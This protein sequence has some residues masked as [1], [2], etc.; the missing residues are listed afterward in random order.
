MVVQTCERNRIR[1]RVRI[2][3]HSPAVGRLCVTGVVTRVATRVVTRVVTAS[4]LK[5]LPAH[6][7]DGR[8]LAS[9]ITM[10]TS[11][12]AGKGAGAVS[13]RTPPA[14]GTGTAA[15]TE[16][17]AGTAAGT[18]VGAVPGTGTTLVVTGTKGSAAQIPLAPGK[19]DGTVG[20]VAGAP[21]TS[22][23]GGAVHP[24]FSDPDIGGA[25]HLPF[26]D[27]AAGG[28]V[29]AR[30]ALDHEVN[31]TCSC[32][33]T[34]THT[35]SVHTQPRSECPCERPQALSV[36]RGVSRCMRTGT[37][38]TCD[39]LHAAPTRP[40]P[41][42]HQGCE[43]SFMFPCSFFCF[44][45]A[46]GSPSTTRWRHG[47][48]ARLSFAPL[49]VAA[50]NCNAVSMSVSRLSRAAADARGGGHVLLRARV[51]GGFQTTSMGVNFL[52]PPAHRRARPTGVQ[53]TCR[54]A[55]GIE[56]P[57]DS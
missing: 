24:P 14:A 4:G 5:L 7:V 36:S 15:G 38:P 41:L 34:Q 33:A 51:R 49:T 47:L 20:A 53:R 48:V 28:A 50:C 32:S 54:Q 40:P 56:S 23:P 16:T 29:H 52:I 35:R 2:D 57:A 19:F 17:A 9:A 26:S 6:H 1:K 30:A 31:T 55:H 46:V 44:C 11:T 10:A 45:L 21:A 27:P 42:S 12:G 25:A 37:N 43:G 3:R 39:G 18:N 22:S 13:A 8:S